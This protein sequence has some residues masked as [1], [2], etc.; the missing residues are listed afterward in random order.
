MMLV[1]VM[2]MAV[3][4]VMMRVGHVHLD[5]SLHGAVCGD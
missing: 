3:V 5:R 2:M 4:V 1:V